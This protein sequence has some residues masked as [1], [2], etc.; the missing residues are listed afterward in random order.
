MSHTPSRCSRL[1]R[2]GFTLS[3]LVLFASLSPV[4]HGQ[5][6]SGDRQLTQ[7][8]QSRPQS[9]TRLALVIG[10]GS[11]KNAK[12]LRN[13]PSDAR[14]T[15][16]AIRE[17]GFEVIIGVDKSQRE[18]KQ[19]IRDFGQRL[20]TNG[21]VGV[22]YFAGHGV[23]AKGHNYLIPIEA[24]I[25]TESDLED[26]AVDI[27]YLLSLMDEAQNSLNVVILDA[28][29]NNPFVRSFRSTQGGLA[30]VKAPTGTL[31]AYATAPD[32]IAGDGVGTNSPYTEELLKQM[33]TP[34][35]LIETMF[36]RVTEQVSSRTGGQQEPWFS[37]N[38][39][40]DFYFRGAANAADAKLTLSNNADEATP[41]PE[42][43]AF[44]LSYWESIKGSQDPEDFK[45]YLE[46]YPSGQFSTLA[47]NSL[48]R[49]E[50]AKVNDRVSNSTPGTASPSAAS[51]SGGTRSFSHKEAGLQFEL[52]K[53][54]KA[55]PDGEVITVSTA[56]DSL[57]MVFWVP[58]E[59]TFD[60]AV[61][62]LGD[63][64]GKT[65]KNIKTTDKGTSDTLNGMPHFSSGGTGTVGGAKI[66][67]SV[68]VLAAKKVVII[69]TF[70]AP[71]IA[72]KHAAEAAKFIAS[73][74]KTE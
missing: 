66:E 53:G 49:L 13:P 28:C 34:G 11:Y 72:E 17:L 8:P 74:K 59:N 16:A 24:D 19:L 21:G 62:D 9:Q 27:N 55:K 50:A 20:R 15:A 73:I 64:L 61:K 36:R 54:W 51:D 37:A 47:R 12:P 14:A 2:L 45:S 7:G 41:K 71:G 58:D 10:N 48:R 29:R 30:Q 60:A 52:P 5:N 32:S 42:P 18:M 4:L 6:P 68:D 3:S 57:Q 56:D 33:R 1:K 69:L 43:A 22:F 44:E 26:Q 39:K 40:G 31:I 70:A 23:Q 46:T 67:W 63:E 38:I 65:I 35:V 25:Q